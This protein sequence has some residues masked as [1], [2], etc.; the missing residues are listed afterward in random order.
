MSHEPQLAAVDYPLGPSM[1]SNYS[2]D[3]LSYYPWFWN[4]DLGPRTLYVSQWSKDDDS[5][6]DLLSLCL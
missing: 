1:N 3:M 6:I 5:G 2:P 4:E